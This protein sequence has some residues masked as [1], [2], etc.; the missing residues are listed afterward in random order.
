MFLIGTLEEALWIVLLIFFAVS[1]Y[2]WS[3]KKLANETVAV[4]LTIFIVY[5]LFFRFRSLVWL[6]AIGVVI[7]W[8]YG[9]DIKNILKKKWFIL[10]IFSFVMMFF[11]IF[12]TIQYNFY[13]FTFLGLFIY[14]IAMPSIFNIFLV[15]FLI[16]VSFFLNSFFA[17]F[18]PLSFF[19]IIF[20]VV[21]YFIKGEQKP[22]QNDGMSGLEDLF[23]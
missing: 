3:K 2:F 6:V 12:F 14:A 11:F 15:I 21:M 8:V 13:L 1:I 22:Q 23:K 20:I 4:L 16:V 9:S 18:L 19:L 17:F 7:Y 10:D 5:I